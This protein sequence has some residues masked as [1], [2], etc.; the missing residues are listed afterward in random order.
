MAGKIMHLKGL[1]E[2]EK[3][4]DFSAPVYQCV[5]EHAHVRLEKKPAVQ[6]TTEK[7]SFTYIIRATVHFVA[8]CQLAPGEHYP[9]NL[10]RATF[11]NL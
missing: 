6:E 3:L 9:E 1:S 11:V 10:P 2:Y 5:V 4:K 8:L 7:D